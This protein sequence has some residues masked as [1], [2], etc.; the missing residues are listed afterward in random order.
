[1]TE[2]KATTLSYNVV[3]NKSLSVLVAHVIGCIQQGW[4]PLGGVTMG[5]KG[6]DFSP[7]GKEC[8]YAQALVLR[9]VLPIGKVVPPT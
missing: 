6:N 5:M 4:E 3:E 1:M 2:E 9:S 8:F 7:H